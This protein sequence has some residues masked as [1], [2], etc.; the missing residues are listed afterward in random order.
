MVPSRQRCQVLAHTHRPM[1]LSDTCAARCML[2][3]QARGHVLGFE[4]IVEYGEP[5]R[6]FRVS[7]AND[8]NNNQ[9]TWSFERVVMEVIGVLGLSKAERGPLARAAAVETGNTRAP[10]PEAV[11]R[12]YAVILTRFPD[13]ELYL[14]QPAV[15]YGLA[16]SGKSALILATLWV[17]AYIRRTRGILVLMNSA[18][19]Y[20][21]VAKRDVP[22]FNA[23]LAGEA[24]TDGCGLAGVGFRGRDKK[25]LTAAGSDPSTFVFAMGNGTQLCAVR[26]AFA[27]SRTRYLLVTDEADVMVKNALASAASATAVGK[28]FDALAAQATGGCVRVSATPFGVLNQ[29]SVTPKRSFFLPPGPNYRGLASF[30]LR[31]ISSSVRRDCAALAGVVH[32]A[33]QRASADPRRMH[34]VAG[35]VNTEH[36]NE[37]QAAQAQAIAATVSASTKVYVFNSR[38]G[39]RAVLVQ[40]DGRQHPTPYG[41]VQDLFAEF[42]RGPAGASYVIVSSMRAGRAVSFRPRPGLG[43]GGLVFMVYTPADSAHCASMIQ[44]LRLC[45]N[46]PPHYPT[47]TLWCPQRV[48]DA[49]RAELVNIERM[50]ALTSAMACDTRSAIINQQYQHIGGYAHDRRE[51]DDTKLLVQDMLVGAEFG[52]HEKALEAARTAAKEPGLVPVVMTLPLVHV[53]VPGFHYIKRTMAEQNKLRRQLLSSLGE[54]GTLQVAWDASRFEDLHKLSRRYSRCVRLGKVTLPYCARY[55]AG[56]SGTSRD[57]WC[58][59][60]VVEWK[61]EFYSASMD[62]DSLVGGRAYLYQ[63]TRGTWRVYAP[64]AGGRANAVMVRACRRDNKTDTDTD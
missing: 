33:L 57:T 13:I 34:Y 50:I 53:H 47:L 52:S 22:S 59:V 41:D 38:E 19:S 42:E 18:D 55:V 4:Q 5:R 44:A 40:G 21:Q 3:L 62:V 30:E 28:A 14:D 35:L 29:E 23:W 15:V 45:G 24:G 16:Q 20:N 43:G 58:D 9:Q 31:T 37:R 49:V 48:Q 8:S 1:A 32:D 10:D 61:R 36:T 27:A 56:F 54:E 63:T 11:S 7:V 2:E 26:R 46:Y 25:A 51:V 39:G 17:G 64:E 12:C 6:D 60:P